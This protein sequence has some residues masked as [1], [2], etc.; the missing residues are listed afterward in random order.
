M[1]LGLLG[2]APGPQCVC[3]FHVFTGL[4]SVRTGSSLTPV[5][6]LG[7]SFC[8]F[9]LSNFSLFICVLL[10]YALLLSLRSPFSS[11]ERQKGSGF[12]WERRRGG[13][14]KGERGDTSQDLPCEEK[15][16]IFN[17]R[18]VWLTPDGAEVTV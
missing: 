17:K 9:A 3:Q 11:N 2:P 10:C 13:A 6:S 7:L 12:G 5:P 15:K 8:C 14:G 1:W 4:P 18:C 16:S